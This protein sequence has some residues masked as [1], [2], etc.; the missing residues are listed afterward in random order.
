MLFVEIDPVKV[1]LVEVEV[2]D[3]AVA[4]FEPAAFPDCS[5]GHGEPVGRLVGS[6]VVAGAD[7]PAWVIPDSRVAEAA[8]LGSQ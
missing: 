1:E 8:E 6:S 7:Q 4:V 5:L 3:V 2:D